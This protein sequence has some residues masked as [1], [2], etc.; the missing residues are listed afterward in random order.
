MGELI[1]ERVEREV[2][3]MVSDAGKCVRRLGFAGDDEQ[4]G[5]EFVPVEPAQQELYQLLLRH[6]VDDTVPLATQ[7]AAVER[8][9]DL[10]AKVWFD[11]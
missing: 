4:T 9:R 8:Y 1:G 3:G 7:L 6:F 2:A 10:Q 5:T 11:F